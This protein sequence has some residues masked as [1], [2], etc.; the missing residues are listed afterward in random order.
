MAGFLFEFE[1]A[2]GTPAEPSAL[3]SAVPNWGPGET[4]HFGHR[5]LRISVCAMTMPT[6][7]RY[8]SLRT[9]PDEPL[10]PR[11]DVS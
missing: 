7:L 5:T 10:A 1:K 3:S 4:I 9:W 8:W 6:S 2:D 11:S